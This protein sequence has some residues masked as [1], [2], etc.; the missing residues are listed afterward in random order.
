MHRQPSFSAA[1]PGALS[2]LGGQQQQPQ[3]QPGSPPIEPLSIFGNFSPFASPSKAPAL[4]LPVPSHSP[5][6]AATLLSDLSPSAAAFVSRSPQ[7]PQAA[8]LGV[9]SSSL[10]NVA[11][12]S[13]NGGFS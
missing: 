1:A 13:Q 6:T 2:P 12:Q 9:P 4:P 7:R 10:R 3:Q 8:P 11:R 5:A